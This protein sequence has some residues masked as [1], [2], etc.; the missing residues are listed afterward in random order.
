MHAT[1]VIAVLWTARLETLMWLKYVGPSW[2]TLRG[3]T[4]GCVP[5]FLRVAVVTII[6]LMVVLSPSI[7]CVDCINLGFGGDLFI[8]FF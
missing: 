8:V 3:G 7:G 6:V 2:L 4:L 5:V 1:T